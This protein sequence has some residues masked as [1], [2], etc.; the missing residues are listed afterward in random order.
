MFQK[1]MS[2]N[3][4]Q[5]AKGTHVHSYD[6]IDIGYESKFKTSGK[7]EEKGTRNLKY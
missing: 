2:N 1:W 7:T 4:M 3:Y 5:L 6:M